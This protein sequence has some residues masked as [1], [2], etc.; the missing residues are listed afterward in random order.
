MLGVDN[1]AAI[2]AFDS[3]LRNPGHH[4]ACEALHIAEWL[5]K[6][7]QR[8]KAALTICWTAGHEGLVGNELADKEAKEAAKGHTSET[9]LL[10]SYLRK[11]LLINTSAVKAAYRSKLKKEWQDGWRESK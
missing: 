3:E 7:R 10:P 9:K 6:K 1:Q 4:L 8:N 5:K 11:P 2:K